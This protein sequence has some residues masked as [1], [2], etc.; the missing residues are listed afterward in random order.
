MKIEAS[1][2]YKS[3]WLV[4]NLNIERRTQKSKFTRERGE[5]VERE[6]RDRR[7]RDGTERLKK[8]EG[9]GGRKIMRVV[10]IV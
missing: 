9:D 1:K 2:I 7:E 5:R 8:M 6:R 10:L 4:L 3:S